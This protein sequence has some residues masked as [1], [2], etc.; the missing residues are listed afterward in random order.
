M[1]NYAFRKPIIGADTN[2]WGAFNDAFLRSAL[3]ELSA[4]LYND[5]GVLKLSKGRIGINDGVVEAISVID[6]ITTLSLVGLTAGRWAAVEM[7]VAGTVVTISIT[8]IAAGTDEGTMPAAVKAAYDYEKRA[9]HL[10]AGKRLIGIAFIKLAGTLGLVINCENGKLG[11]K[12]IV[13]TQYIS[14]A[15]VLT[16]SYVASYV[17]EI[18]AWN[19]DTAPSL[20]LSYNYRVTN[21]LSIDV[22]IY[23]DAPGT[24]HFSLY[25]FTNAADPTLIAGGL[26]GFSSITLSLARR[27][28]SVFDGAAFSSVLV[29]RGFVYVSYFL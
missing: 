1:A 18:G 6:T 27:T 13:T 23:Q 28:G 19:M 20:D 22:V 14:S 11:F 26:F 15:G 10:T 2:A 25:N 24:Q 16:L 7:A 4:E 29:N 3:G 21:P 8:S 9:Y 12:N 17:Q 5:G